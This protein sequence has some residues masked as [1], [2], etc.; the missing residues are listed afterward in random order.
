MIPGPRNL[1]FVDRFF[2]TVVIGVFLF[3][4]GFPLYKITKKKVSGDS[5]E[6]MFL[7]GDGF[8]KI[9]K[10]THIL[11]SFKSELRRPVDRV[12]STPTGTFVH[13]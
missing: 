5:K 3:L 13:V 4:L 8:S 10:S 1:V 7:L 11:F 12:G 2:H 6:K 9:Q